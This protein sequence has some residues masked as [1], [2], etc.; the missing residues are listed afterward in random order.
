MFSQA[1]P[2]LLD[3][4]TL[5]GIMRKNPVVIP[6]AQAYLKVYNRFIFS[7]ITR[8]EILRG[9]K[10]K[11]ATSQ[12]VAFERICENSQILALT[13]DVIMKA[14]SIYA[15]L[16]QRGMLI[17]DDDILI[18]ATGLIY[19]L[20]IIT[21]NENHFNRIKGLHVENWLKK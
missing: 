13:D 4:D 16:H 14:A 1:I 11:K 7:I 9:L 21:N 12:L 17:G 20:T 2:V 18:A 8:Y 15:D 5:S 3:T 10:A 19:D 6:R